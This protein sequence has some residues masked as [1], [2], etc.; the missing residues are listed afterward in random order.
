MWE[1]DY[2]I[3]GSMYDKDW[4]SDFLCFLDAEIKSEI[5]YEHKIWELEASG[6]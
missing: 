1:I 3:F 2:F 4:R 6:I 5:A